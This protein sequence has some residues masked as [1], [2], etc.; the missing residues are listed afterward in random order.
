MS[1]EL[2]LSVS[3]CKT[4]SDCRKKFHFTYILK[5]PR[6]DADYLITGKFA[7][8]ALE[9]FHK[10]YITDPIS[11][12]PYNRVMAQSFKNA[13]TEYKDRMTPTMKDE[14]WQMLNDY[15]KLLN[16]KGLPTILAV[17]EEFEFMISDRVK[18]IGVIDRIEVDQDGVLNLSDYKTTK[19]KK[20]LKDDFFQLHTYAMVQMAANPEIEKIKLSYIL[21]RHN[22]EQITTEVS[23]DKIEEIKQKYIEYALQ[24]DEEKEYPANP[25]ILCN[26]CPFL[27]QCKEGQ[28]KAFKKPQTIYGEVDW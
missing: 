5:L 11:T 15:L 12:E 13:W 27:D 6:K 22:F 25:T 7:H 23:R 4:F 18:L 16:G 28:T 3:K 1:S 9:D 21:L 26:Y 19:N 10:H 8:K 14:C 2:R 20:Y 17:E 24:I